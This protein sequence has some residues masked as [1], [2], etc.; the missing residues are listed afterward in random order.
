MSMKYISLK[1][2][3]EMWGVTSRRIQVLCAS[4]RI[5]G[6]MKISNMWIIPANATKPTDARIKNGEFINWR[7]RESYSK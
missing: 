3:S 5:D 2:A 7:N 6:A 1:E 4:G